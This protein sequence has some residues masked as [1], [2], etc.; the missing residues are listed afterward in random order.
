MMDLLPAC[1]CSPV[2]CWSALPFYLIYS[3]GHKLTVILSLHILFPS[4]KALF[5][6]LYVADCLCIQFSEYAYFCPHIKI[7]TT[8]HISVFHSFT[9]LLPVFVTV[10]IFFFSPTYNPYFINCFISSAYQGKS[11]HIRLIQ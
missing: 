11:W 8:P 2:F 4:P 7:G 9:W 5:P 10:Y 6:L 1:F 3:F